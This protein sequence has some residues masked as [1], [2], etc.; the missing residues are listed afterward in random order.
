MEEYSRT[1]EDVIGNDGA[2]LDYW[3]KMPDMVKRQLLCSNIVVD[4][5]GELVL[6]AN[7]LRRHVDPP[8][9]VF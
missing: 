3:D 6:Q 2:M 8:A 7:Q 4:T 5:L 9:K 1:V